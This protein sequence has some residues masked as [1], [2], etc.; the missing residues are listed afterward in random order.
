MVNMPKHPP[1]AQV[2]RVS[3]SERDRGDREFRYWTTQ[4][5]AL[6]NGT[7]DEGDMPVSVGTYFLSE[8]MIIYIPITL[9]EGNRENGEEGE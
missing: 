3:I 4:P 2:Y 7:G 9:E 5:K 8:G 6:M 1:D